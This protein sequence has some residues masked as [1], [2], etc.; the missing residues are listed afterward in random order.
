MPAL[1]LLV[2]PVA[3]CFAAACGSDS[4]GSGS[5]PPP[6]TANPTTDINMP[7][8]AQTTGFQ[9]KTKNVALNGGASVSV[10]WVNRDYSGTDYSSTTVTHHIVSDNS[11]FAPSQLLTATA[12]SYTISL[13]A[14]GDYPYHCSIH[15]TTMQGTIHVDP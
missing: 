10:R 13:S 8:G 1:R 4:T 12:P 6:P 14:P 11:A 3:L 9:P 2:V 7:P 5:A 15:P